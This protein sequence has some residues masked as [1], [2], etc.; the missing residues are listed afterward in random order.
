MPVRRGLK[1]FFL[2]IVGPCSWK[3]ASAQGG[4]FFFLVFFF[5]RLVLS[6]ASD[7]GHRPQRLIS[8]QWMNLVFEAPS[9][10]L[11]EKRW[12]FLKVLGLSSA[13]GAFFF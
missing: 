7:S 4:S 11:E 3:T 10:L 12:S 5:G 8:L 9:A 1:S 2:H 6:F 13:N